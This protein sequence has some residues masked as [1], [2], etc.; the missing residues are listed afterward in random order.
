MEA[1]SN[2]G[3]EAHSRRLKVVKWESLHSIARTYSHLISMGLYLKD[4]DRVE[5]YCLR[6]W[7]AV[8]DLKRLAT[9]ADLFP[10]AG[11]ELYQLV[12]SLP[13]GLPA[14]CALNG[15][16]SQFCKNG[17][18]LG[19]L[20]LDWDMSQSDETKENCGAAG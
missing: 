10:N 5:V 1:Q 8:W 4:L 20:S 9:H 6:F 13:E 19:E 17:G 16:Y 11:S 15:F 14:S 2:L 7:K 3:T 12:T 18:A